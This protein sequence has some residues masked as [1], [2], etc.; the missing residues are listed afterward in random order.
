MPGGGCPLGAPLTAAHV[1]QIE[2]RLDAVRA[3]C[4]QSHKRLVGCFQGQ[5]GTDADRR[6]VSAGPRVPTGR[7]EGVPQP[8]APP[9]P[10]FPGRLRL[11]PLVVGRVG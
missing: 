11:G 6:H 8:R 1:P 7:P 3:M 9:C 10:A 5:H 2:R 4:H